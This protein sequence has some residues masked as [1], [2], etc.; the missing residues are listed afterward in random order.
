MIVQDR[1]RL[2]VDPKGGGEILPLHFLKI[3]SKGPLG[4]SKQPIDNQCQ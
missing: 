1:T 3:L 4:N 2:I